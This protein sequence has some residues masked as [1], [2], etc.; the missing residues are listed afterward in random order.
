MPDFVYS[1]KHTTEAA[2][3]T[4]VLVQPLTVAGADAFASVEPDD[5]ACRV[6]SQD[7]RWLAEREPS[8]P[9]VLRLDGYDVTVGTLGVPLRTP[10]GCATRVLLYVHPTPDNAANEPAIVC[11]IEFQNGQ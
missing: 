4:R 10:T 11:T 8:T 7:A 6:I 9:A 5:Q 3:D 2:P 1:T